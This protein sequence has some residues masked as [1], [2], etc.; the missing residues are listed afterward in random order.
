MPILSTQMPTINRLCRQ[1]YVHVKS[2]FIAQLASY[3]SAPGSHC[4]K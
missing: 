4:I 1:K 3:P 2:P